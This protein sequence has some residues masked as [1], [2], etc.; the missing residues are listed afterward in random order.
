[1]NHEF[2]VHDIPHFKKLCKKCHHG[3]NSDD[4]KCAR[5]KE[6]TC[7]DCGKVYHY[8]KNL[9]LHIKTVHTM[10]KTHL[11]EPCGKYFAD[12]RLLKYHIYQSHSKVNCPHCNKLILNK[13][14]LK[15]HSA[16]EHGM[17][18]G[19]IFCNTCPKTVFFT[20]FHYKKHMMEK[21]GITVEENDK[22][23]SNSD[24]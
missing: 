18:D 15:R 12:A 24:M 17:T 8:I 9:K 4:H 6:F 2:K 3:I 20:K 1:M 16:L 23:K 13:G 19:C 5:D 10:E 11:C 21:H 14:E 22:I 7:K